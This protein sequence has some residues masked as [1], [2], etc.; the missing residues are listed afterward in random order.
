MRYN[1]FANLRLKALALLLSGVLWFTVAGE[2]VVERSLRVPL[3]FRNIPQSLDIVGNAPD[4]VDVRLTELYE[5]L[6][7]VV[8]PIAVAQRIQQTVDAVATRRCQC[9]RHRQAYPRVFLRAH[10]GLDHRRRGGGKTGARQAF[11]RRLPV[12]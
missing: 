8:T 4:S 3:E 12:S 2:H 10:G 9:E 5:I 1:P 7:C 11:V 6:E